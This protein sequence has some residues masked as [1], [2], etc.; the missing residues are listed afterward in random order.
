MQPLPRGTPL[1][2]PPCEIRS[3]FEKIEVELP[4]YRG[5]WGLLRGSIETT[6]TQEE[7]TMTNS[8]NQKRSDRTSSGETTARQPRAVKRSSVDESW[9]DEEDRDSM[10][11]MDDASWMRT[12]MSSF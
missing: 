10:D 8:R 7:K 9:D 1:P 12:R 11:D 6:R 4:H 3:G 5:E 2:H